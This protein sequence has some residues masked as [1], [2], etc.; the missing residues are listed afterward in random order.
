MILVTEKSG[1][2]PP[3]VAEYIVTNNLNQSSLTDV[4]FESL[5][6]MEN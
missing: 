5:G 3:T 1:L 2:K 6:Q 4:E